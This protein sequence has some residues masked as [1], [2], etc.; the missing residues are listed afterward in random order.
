MYIYI[1]LLLH[2]HSHWFFITFNCTAIQNPSFFITDLEMSIVFLLPLVTCVFWLLHLTIL[3]SEYQPQKLPWN[4]F[5]SHPTAE[6]DE[7]PFFFFICRHL[8]STPKFPIGYLSNVPLQPFNMGQPQV[9][10]HLTCVLSLSMQWFCDLC[11]IFTE[12]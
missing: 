10:C 4:F 5:T 8:D 3:Q 7:S 6:F 9:T 1:F 2:D 12:V 11:N